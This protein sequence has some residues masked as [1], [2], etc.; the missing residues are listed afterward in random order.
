VADYSPGDRIVCMIRDR[1]I[2]NATEVLYDEI[3]IFDIIIPYA[4]G[5]ILYVP[6]DAKL[7]DCMELNSFNCIRFNIDFKFMGCRAY[8]I[9]G[10]KVFQVYSRIDGMCCARCKDFFSMAEP[11]QENGTMICYSCRA[12]PYR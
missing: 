8:Y 9:T 5:L 7:D 1:A 11:N 10:Y 6:D 2:I 12:N 4:E 3:R